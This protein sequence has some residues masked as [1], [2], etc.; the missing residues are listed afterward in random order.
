MGRPTAAPDVRQVVPATVI[1]RSIVRSTL[2]VL[3]TMARPQNS[4]GNGRGWPVSRVEAEHY[5]YPLTPNFFEK[6]C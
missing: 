3:S 5:T 6:E 1:I 4:I 2:R